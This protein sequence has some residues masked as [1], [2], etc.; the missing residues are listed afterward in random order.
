ML[1]NY[2][3]FEFKAEETNDEGIVKGYAS[4]F[5][6]ID[7]GLD[8]VDKGAFTKSLKENKGVFPILADHN[9][10][11]QIGWNEEGEE[12]S[13]GLF[14]K[15]LVDLNVQKGREKYSLA[16]KAAKIGA[17]MGLS[18][19]YIT[20]KA[21]PDRDR[22]MVRRLKELK[23]F[24]YSFVTF[25]MNIEATVSSIKS[26]SH[27]EQAQRVIQQAHEFGISHDVLLQALHKEVALVEDPAKIGQSIDKIIETL[28]TK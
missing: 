9:P 2:M 8:V 28:R 7:Q 5:G 1:L 14:V 15:G 6:N 21:E 3:T 4:T 19:G 16:K 25:P 27:I 20:I 17:K 26:L 11:D 12:D 18:I 23:L 13:K 22:P 24:E 10:S